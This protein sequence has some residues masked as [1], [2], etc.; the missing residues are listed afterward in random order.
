[1]SGRDCLPSSDCPVNGQSNLMEEG[2]APRHLREWGT[3]DLTVPPERRGLDREP[4]SAPVF[5]QVRCPTAGR[6]HFRP[7]SSPAARRPKHGESRRVSRP[8]R[9]LGA[10][11]RCV[12][13]CGRRCLLGNEKTYRLRPRHGRRLELKRI[14][15]GVVRR[16]DGLGLRADRLRGSVRCQAGRDLGVLEGLLGCGCH[17]WTRT[18]LGHRQ[19]RPGTFR[20][21]TPGPPGHC[22]RTSRR[23]ATR[24][25]SRAITC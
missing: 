9:A 7:A 4:R 14:P 25:R 11:P 12:R 1:M 15:I 17:A 18:H 24:S 23:R 10:T 22:S 13:R 19:A 2:C 6:P 5:G 8:G 16:L 3:L 21:S 20:T